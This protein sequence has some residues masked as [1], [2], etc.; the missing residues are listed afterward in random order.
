MDFND[1]ADWDS[2]PLGARIEQRSTRSA[3]YVTAWAEQAYV[4]MLPSH[5]RLTLLAYESG[6]I[7]Q[8]MVV[9]GVG[10]THV[11]SEGLTA[12]ITMS[13]RATIHFDKFGAI[14]AAS[15]ILAMIFNE[16]PENANAAL[17]GHGIELRR[18]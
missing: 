5:F 6:P 18:V 8:K 7:Q 2:L 12:S 13:E 15:T 11:V 16:D 3:D 4:V 9:D 1:I 10:P 14:A 17:R